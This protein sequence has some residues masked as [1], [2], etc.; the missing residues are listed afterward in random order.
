MRSYKKLNEI[1]KNWLT[2]THTQSVF[3]R[4]IVLQVCSWWLMCRMIRELIS[5]GS[6]LRSSITLK[7]LSD[8]WLFCVCVS[9]LLWVYLKAQQEIHCSQWQ[10]MFP[11]KQSNWKLNGSCKIPSKYIYIYSFC[12]RPAAIFKFCI[13]SVF[14][15][16]LFLFKNIGM[17]QQ[18]YNKIHSSS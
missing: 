18:S 3:K 7:M 2:H 11:K 4:K 12:T 14:V 1:K 13:A 15:F 17:F 5:D 6:L 9:S 10:N 16:D 8:A